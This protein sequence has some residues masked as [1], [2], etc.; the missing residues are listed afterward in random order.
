MPWKGRHGD[1][2]SLAREGAQ[3]LGLTPHTNGGSSLGD[4]RPV[5]QAF[6]TPH[7]CPAQPL[8]L[9]GPNRAAWL[10]RVRTMQEVFSL[11]GTS[12]Q[13]EAGRFSMVVLTELSLPPRPERVRTGKA[14]KNREAETWV[15][16]P[17][18]NSDLVSGREQPM[19]TL[20]SIEDTP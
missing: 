9:S 12:T 3:E 6:S 18:R 19:V 16:A 17:T 10:T 15:K 7:L 14:C 5:L 13:R 1:P 20:Q 11:V 2:G 4:S 8:H